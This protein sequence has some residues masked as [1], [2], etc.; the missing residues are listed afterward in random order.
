MPKLLEIIHYLKRRHEGRAE[1]GVRF[2][3]KKPIRIT[4]L[5]A[6]GNYVISQSLKYT[7]GWGGR[8]DREVFLRPLD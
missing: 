4:C 3:V 6:A 5:F 8:E 7:F 2:T 1:K